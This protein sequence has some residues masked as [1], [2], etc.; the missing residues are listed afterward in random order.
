VCCPL[1]FR[2]Y[3]CH[4]DKEEPDVYVSLNMGVTCHNPAPDKS[5]GAEEEGR[6]AGRDQ[7]GPSAGKAH[8]P[9]DEDDPD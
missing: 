7:E 5:A 1:R 4:A 8:G 6:Q 9:D 2:I 3:S